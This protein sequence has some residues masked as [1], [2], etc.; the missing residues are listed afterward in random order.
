LQESKLHEIY[1]IY[2]HSGKCFY[3]VNEVSEA[4][5]FKVQLAKG[6]EKVEYTL[7]VEKNVETTQIIKGQ[8]NN[9]TQEQERIIFLIIREILTTNPNVKVDK[10]NFYLENKFQ[11]IKGKS[12]IYYIHDGYKLSLKQTEE[13][14]CL[15][16]GIKNRV[17]GDLSV[18]D[19]LNDPAYNYG[20]TLDER[21]ENL[22]GKRFVPEGSTKSKVIYDI[23][24]DRTPK[25]TTIN[26][27]KE[28][29]SNYITYY[30]KVFQKII[31]YP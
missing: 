16:I 3:A 9:F 31:Q 6:K 26:T 19:A 1:G 18:Y 5:D 17:K 12:Q 21:I 30:E 14:L 22:I 13:G 15:I 4:K 25:N 24:K 11:K 7:Q 23:S 8:K 29:Y 2:Y 20:E 10:D 28:T 27:F